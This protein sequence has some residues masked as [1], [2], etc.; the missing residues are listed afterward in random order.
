MELRGD[1]SESERQR[2]RKGR[3]TINLS[4]KPQAAMPEDFGSR[5][6]LLRSQLSRLVN[7]L[8]MHY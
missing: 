6:S 7:Q 3:G 5:D 1:E 8:V 4:P 2:E